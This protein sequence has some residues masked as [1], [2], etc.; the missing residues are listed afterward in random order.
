MI[1]FKKKIPLIFSSFFALSFFFKS[2][3]LA[4]DPP[5]IKDLWK[6]LANAFEFFTS[7]I[8]IAAVAMFVYG[9]YMWIFSAG[10]PQ[11][12]KKAQGVLTYAV[13]G[14]VFYIGLRLILGAILGVLDL[15]D[16]PAVPFHD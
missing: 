9:A 10:D 2:F 5:E 8:G 14:L 1:D 7:F 11:A 15:G 16:L 3:V 13:L 12:V 6:I 4:N